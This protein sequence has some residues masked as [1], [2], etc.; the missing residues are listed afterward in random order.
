[1][2]AT[3]GIAMAAFYALRLYQRAMHNP[4]PAGGS[5]REIGWTDGLVLVPLVGV[6]V[7]LAFTPGTILERG[8]AS[9]QDKV[10]A[11]AAADDDR[12]EASVA[13]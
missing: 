4:L 7:A 6:I 10:G 8:E 11:V 12:L 3:A 9:V 1:V 2:V 5:S 13:P